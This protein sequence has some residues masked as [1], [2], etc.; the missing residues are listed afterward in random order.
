MS[1]GAGTVFRRGGIW[2]VQIWIDGQRHRES[3]KSTKKADAIRL[4][5]KLLGQKARGELVPAVKGDSINRHIDSFMRHVKSEL[6]EGSK[7]MYR[8]AFAHVKPV[9]GHLKPGKLT[10]D[11]L[12]AYREKREKETVHKFNRKTSAS[13]DTGKPVSQTTINRELGAL[14]SALNYAQETDSS[15]RFYIPHFPMPKENN[16]RKG[17][18][19]DE[20]FDQ[21][22][23]SLPYAGVRALSASSFYTGV[24]TGEL[25][26]ANWDDV[27]FNAGV[28]VIY[29][30]KNGEPRAVPIL[31][32]L[33]L[34]TLLEAKAERDE[35]WPECEA[36]F[37]YEGKRLKDPKRSWNTARKKI[38]K[39]DLLFHDMRRSANRNMRNDGLPQQMRMNVMGQK[40]A[41]MDRR[42]G[43]I[44]LAD[45]QLA[46]QIMEKHTG[47]QKHKRGPKTAPKTGP[48]SSTK[49]VSS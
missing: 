25:T 36:V 12:R 29:D 21:L 28:A 45:I 26:A 46:K 10:T 49:S 42:Y 11:M 8:A 2:Y 31:K 9:F 7:R 19:K 3:S 18:L 14:R 33:M 22:C 30:T 27:D 32:G 41:S 37:A 39:E 35:L 5:D 6:D 47:T 24:R 20:R 44:D 16:T 48:V 34:D 13:F 15:I 17:Y 23:K 1:Y 40:T 43:I 38:G 4:R